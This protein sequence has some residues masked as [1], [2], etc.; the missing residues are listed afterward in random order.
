LSNWWN[1]QKG[2]FFFKTKSTRY[3]AATGRAEVEKK[4]DEKASINPS[5]GNMPGG[6]ILLR[7]LTS[8]CPEF[9]RV[10]SE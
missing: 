3:H 6:A 5:H 1:E 2:D 9:L 10:L 8:P 4:L 7:F